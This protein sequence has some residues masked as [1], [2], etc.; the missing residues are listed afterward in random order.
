MRRSSLGAQVFLSILGVSLGTALMVAVFARWALSAAFDNYLASLPGGTTATG[1]PRMGRMM[2][3][4]AEQT[5]IASMDRSAMSAAVV[6]I[7]FAIV[8]AL[9]L[10]AYLA[11]PLRRLEGAAQR[12]AAGDLSHR[13]AVDGPLEVAALGDAFNEMADSLEKAEDLRRRLVADVA[14]ELRNPLAAARGQAEGMADGVLPVDDARLASL[15]EDIEHLS[16]LV[17]DLQELAVA[18]AGRLRYEMKPVDLGI[19]AYGEVERARGLV[20]SGVELSIHGAS[21]PALVVGDE[22]R[23]LQVVRNLLSNAARHTSEGSIEIS[24]ARVGDRIRFT[25]TDT[26]EGITPADLPYVFE[27]FYRADEARAAYSG[28]AGLGLAISR[29]IV[30]DHGGD[31]FAESTP[32]KGTSIGFELPAVGVR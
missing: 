27:R 1:R 3:G 5:F 19:L 8:V 9:L 20:A 32:G 30:R 31:V 23:L 4:A 11:R 12:L 21:V 7:L 22:R 2:L 26:G 25:I 15:V 29:T 10:A 18:E 17:D 6:A 14:H 16:A 28:G 13:V 24:V